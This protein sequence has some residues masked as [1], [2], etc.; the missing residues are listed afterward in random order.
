M[1]TLIKV[2]FFACHGCFHVS[3]LTL[4][5]R[6]LFSNAQTIGCSCANNHADYYFICMSVTDN[7]HF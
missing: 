2:V 3:S 1:L 4:L 6:H 7:R 5:L